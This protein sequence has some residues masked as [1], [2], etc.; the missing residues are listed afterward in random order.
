MREESLTEKRVALVTGGASGIGWATAARLA[1]SGSR[2]VVAD[3]DA[4]KARERARELGPDHRWLRVD[5]GDLAGA[6]DMVR[7]AAAFGRLDVLVNNAGRTTS[8]GVPL[9]EDSRETFD[10]IMAVNL[11]GG[12]AAAEEAARI[13]AMQGGGAIVNVASGAAFRAIPLR[14]AYSPSKAGV[15]AMTQKLAARWAPHRVRVNVVAPGFVGTELLSRLIAEGRLDPSDALRK[16]PLGRMGTPEEIADC[17]AFMTSEAAGAITGCALKADG[18]SQAFGGSGEAA[19]RLGAEPASPPEGFPVAAIFGATSIGIACAERLAG[20]GM[21]VVLA[22]DR[23]AFSSPCAARSQRFATSDVN[24]ADD[25]AMRGFLS[26]LARSHGRLD[27]VIDARVDFNAAS[28][29]RTAADT[30]G[31]LRASGPI[32]LAQGYGSIVSIVRSWACL[33][34]PAEAA[35]EAAIEMLSRTACCEWGGSNIRVNTVAVTGPDDGQD[36]KP[37]CRPLVAFDV[38][39]AAGFLISSQASYVTGATLDV[40]VHALAGGQAA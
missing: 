2:V 29:S 15:L 20:R 40:G 32:L 8:G 26:S 5:M 17:I 19:R 35:E 6:V 10:G 18:G 1:S 27:A 38:A 37:A 33:D 22:D 4:A 7:Q 16:I 23:K 11:S 3:L 21:T 39:A 36:A 25:A 12:L 14:S 13:M 31:L 30:H 9:V 34:D 28:R 24:L